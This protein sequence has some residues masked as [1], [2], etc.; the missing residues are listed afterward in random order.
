M[1]GGV[2]DLPGEH[3][4]TCSLGE[5]E[6]SQARA[7]QISVVRKLSDN[8]VVGVEGAPLVRTASGKAGNI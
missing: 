8:L 1:A 7:F 3:A 5:V 6:G 2:S 4:R